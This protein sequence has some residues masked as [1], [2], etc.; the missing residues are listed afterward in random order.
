MNKI[1]AIVVTYNRKELLI[2]C[3]D[4]LLRQNVSFFDILIV[5]NASTDGTEE[6]CMRYV[7]EEDHI[8]YQ[9]TG[10]NIGGAGGFHFGLK[11]G[12]LHRYDYFWLMDDDTI[13]QEN[14]L[15]MLWKANEQLKGDYGFLSSRAVWTDGT[16]CKMNTPGLL[17]YS[18]YSEY[19]AVKKGLVKV[20]WVTFVS[21]F[22]KRET[23]EEM[24]LP[25]KEFFIWCDDVEYTKRIA[26]KYTGYFVIHSKV[27]HK[28]KSNIGSDVSVDD[29]ERVPRY[30]YEYRNCVY[31]AKH[32]G[33]VWILNQVYRFFSILFR[34][35]V[36]HA[37]HKAIRYWTVWKGFV[38]GI[39]FE[40]QIEYVS[41]DQGK[42]AIGSDCEHEVMG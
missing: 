15:E 7:Q 17:G 22:V 19:A 16:L 39:W 5:D 9:N 24:G 14:A 36:N 33:L 20:D 2:E 8:L 11:Y 4:A 28:M 3:L 40:P 1:L 25:I 35:T 42:E 12:V 32:S 30:F 37:N 23:V 13:A 29:V 26:S 34:I 27:V 10:K 31:I 18:A 6:V 41:S 21:F 38:S